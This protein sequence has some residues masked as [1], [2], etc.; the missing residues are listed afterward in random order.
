[1]DSATL[2]H[3]VRKTLGVADIHA[4]SFIYGQKHDRELDMARWQAEAAGVQ[5]HRVIDISFFGAFFR[6]FLFPGVQRPGRMN[7]SPFKTL[8]IS[9]FLY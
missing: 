9:K 5:D 2:L 6:G 3:H 1:M 8:F 7:N 4:L